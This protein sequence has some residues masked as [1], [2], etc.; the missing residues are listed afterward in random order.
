MIGC[1]ASRHSE[2]TADGRAVGDRRTAAAAGAAQAEG[3]KAPRAEPGGPHRHRLRA[4]DG[5]AL[6]DA[7]EGDGLRVRFDV[8]AEAARLAGG[9]G[10][11]PAAPDLA[12]QAGRGGR[13]RLVEGVPGLGERARQRGARRSVRTRRTLRQTGLGAPRCFGPRGRTARRSSQRHQ[14]PRQRRSSRRSWTR[15]WTRSS[16]SG[17]R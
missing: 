2:R 4:Q 10:V 7:P 14:R 12:G 13:D 3:W 5:H 6:G 11:A 1:Y 15:S 9:R 8:L 16:R 17:V